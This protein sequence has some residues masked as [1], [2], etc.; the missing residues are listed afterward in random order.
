[1]LNKKIQEL[2]NKRIKEEEE[3]SRLYMAMSE[4]CEFNGFEGAAK[5]FSSY[6]SEESEHAGWIYSYMQGLDIMPNVPELEKPNSKF[7]DLP[8]VIRQ[9]HEHEIEISHS[10]NELAKACAEE[11]DFMTMTL[12]LKFCKEQ[13]DEL[14]KTSALVQKLEAFGET[15]APLRLLDN[16]LGKL[17]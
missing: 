11:D 15:P 1:M 6:S 16:E 7:K 10:C 12:A 2:L 13:I 3:S 4:W 8:D 14:T 17:D 9:A 5:A